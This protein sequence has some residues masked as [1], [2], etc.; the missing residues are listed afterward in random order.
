M[1][2]TRCRRED[3]FGRSLK[4]VQDRYKR[5]RLGESKAKF[6]RK[7]NTII[8]TY[9]SATNANIH[10]LFRICL[11]ELTPFLLPVSAKM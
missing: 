6:T 8:D 9:V 7:I 3:E 5:V 11:K 2:N 4:N 1:F 10:K